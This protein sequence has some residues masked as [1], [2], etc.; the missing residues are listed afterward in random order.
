[1]HEKIIRRSSD[2]QASYFFQA[3]KLS[4]STETC[5]GSHV[6]VPRHR[7][8]NGLAFA[9]ESSCVHHLE[10]LRMLDSF[11][12]VSVPAPRKMSVVM[13]NHRKGSTQREIIG[14]S[15]CGA[16]LATATA[17]LL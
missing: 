14:I 4:T 10:L 15:S 6:I 17:R 7:V 5:R 3:H 12:E 8:S 16:R 13:M 9:V 2:P 11:L 1:M